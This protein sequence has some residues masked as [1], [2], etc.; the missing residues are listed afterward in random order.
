MQAVQK[1]QAKGKFYIFSTHCTAMQKGQAL[2]LVTMRACLLNP[3][4]ISELIKD[5]NSV[6]SQCDMDAA[7][8]EK[9]CKEVLLEPHL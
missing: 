5:S 3:N 7:E 6:E 4:Q 8:D 9:C 2:E 1:G